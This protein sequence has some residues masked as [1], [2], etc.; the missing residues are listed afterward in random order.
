MNGPDRE[1]RVGEGALRTPGRFVGLRRLGLES[2]DEARVSADGRELRFRMLLRNRANPIG[3]PPLNIVD[4]DS[5]IFSLEPEDAAL[6]V[7]KLHLDGV[8]APLFLGARKRRIEEL[9]IV[10]S[11]A[12]AELRVDRMRG[13]FEVTREASIEAEPGVYLGVIR[14]PASESVKLDPAIEARL[15]ALG[16]AW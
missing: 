13:L 1:S 6:E 4:R 2:D 14:S 16:Y 15:R 10:V 12:S 11:P 5:L 8:P 7:A 3:Q 9:P